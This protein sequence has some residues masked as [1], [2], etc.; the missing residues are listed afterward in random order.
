M[1]A[2]IRERA[3][4]PIRS[5]CEQESI[6]IATFYNLRK[7]SLQQGKGDPIRKLGR[8]SMVFPEVAKAWLRSMTTAAA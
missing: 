1:D 2:A 3:V 4:Q 6:C 5:F 8:K 7:R